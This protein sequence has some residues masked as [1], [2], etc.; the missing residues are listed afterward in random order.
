M[1]VSCM[2]CVKKHREESSKLGEWNIIVSKDDCTYSSGASSNPKKCCYNKDIVD[3]DWDN[4]PIKS[5]LL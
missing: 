2:V 3:C 4:C 5:S 1:R